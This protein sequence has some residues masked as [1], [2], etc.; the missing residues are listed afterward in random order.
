MPWQAWVKAS[1]FDTFHT[2]VPAILQT[3][4]FTTPG[5]A[6]IDWYICM[7]HKIGVLLHAPAKAMRSFSDCTVQWHFV[8]SAAVKPLSDATW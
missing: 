2:S 1:Q 4:C 3:S 6:D 8:R 5:S 7:V